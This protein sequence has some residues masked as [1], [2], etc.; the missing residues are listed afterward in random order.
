[1]LLATLVPH[2]FSLDCGSIE[3]SALPILRQGNLG[4]R[5]LASPDLESSKMKIDHR[6][7]FGLMVIWTHPEL[8]CQIAG[9]VFW[10]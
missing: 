10:Q 6:G 5:A 2:G 8:F 9:A 3:D 1:V 4:V 7:L